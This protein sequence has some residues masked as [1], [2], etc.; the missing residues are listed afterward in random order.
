MLCVLLSGEY[1]QYSPQG[2]NVATLIASGTLRVGWSVL[3]L[4]ALLTRALSS[5]SLLVMLGVWPN[6]VIAIVS[7]DDEDYITLIQSYK[8]IILSD[9]RI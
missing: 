2:K 9:K 3:A 5:S 7:G 4:A 6:C 1:D 8:N